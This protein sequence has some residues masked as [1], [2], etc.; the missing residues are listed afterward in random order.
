MIS[1]TS[2]YV[3][4]EIGINHNGSLKEAI[5]IADSAINAGAEVIKHQT[6]IIDDEMISEAK[7]L[8]QVI[9][10]KVFLI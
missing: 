6:H 9:Q 5:R 10:I 8:S 4:A 1:A 7:K 2:C 3:V